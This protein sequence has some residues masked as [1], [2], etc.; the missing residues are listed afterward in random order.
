MLS[1]HFIPYPFSFQFFQIWKFSLGEILRLAKESATSMVNDKHLFSVCKVG[2]LG[3]KSSY[4]SNLNSNTFSENWF[5]L[6]TYQC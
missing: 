3:L 2:E 5:S 4:F 6:L 1:E